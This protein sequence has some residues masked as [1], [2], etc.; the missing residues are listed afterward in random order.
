[1]LTHQ[2]G[3]QFFR[4]SLTASAVKRSA[5]ELEADR[6]SGTVLRILGAS[7][8]D[9]QA[10]IS[11]R[12]AA[13]PSDIFP[14]AADRLQ[15]IG[16][17]WRAA[18]VVANLGFGAEDGLPRFDLPP[19]HASATLSLQMKSLAA[20]A[21]QLGDLATAIG[22]ASQQAG[23]S[24]LRYW[25][26]PDG[27]AM[28][29]RLEQITENGAPKT[30]DRWS[31]TLTP[32]RIFSLKS[33]LEALFAADR[34]FYRL[35]VFIVSPHAF[36][37]TNTTLKFKTSIDWLWSGLNR[38]PPSIAS[39]PLTAEYVCTGLIYEFE[40]K[41]PYTDPALRTSIDGKAHLQMARLWQALKQ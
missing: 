31:L 38:L 11:Q 4:H 23:Y 26:V 32:P 29:T 28:A 30:P 27:F 25:A 1:M 37:Q 40:Q 34:G 17:G 20:Q 3:H 19:P 18:G 39:M 5:D 21:N 6:F 33:Y 14:S 16:E 15:A 12:G 41:D 35:I 10:A 7:V 13:K 22:A 24:Q 9:A 36:A 8:R 2:M